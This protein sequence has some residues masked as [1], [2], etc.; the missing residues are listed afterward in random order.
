MTALGATPKLAKQ[1]AERNDD[2]QVWTAARCNRLLRQITSRVAHLRQ[3]VNEAV[4]VNRTTKRAV[5]SSEELPERKR[6]RHTYGG[7]RAKAMPLQERDGNTST[8]PRVMRAL[9]AMRPH[10][11]SSPAGLCCPTP[12]RPTLPTNGLSAVCHRG[13]NT[14][15]YQSRIRSRPHGSASRFLKQISG[16]IPPDRVKIY[17]AILTWLKRLLQLTDERRFEPGRNSLLGMC[18]RKM[19]ECIDEMDAWDRQEAETLGVSSLW[20]SDDAAATIYRQLEAFGGSEHG[21]MPFKHLVKSHVIQVLSRA[22]EEGLFTSEFVTTMA[23]TC[24]EMQCNAEAERLLVAFGQISVLPRERSPSCRSSVPAYS[25]ELC[26]RALIDVSAG[27]SYTSVMLP[28]LGGAISRQQLLIEDIPAKQRSSIWKGALAALHDISTANHGVRFLVPTL[29][30]L[31]SGHGKEPWSSQKSREGMLT[32]LSAGIAAAAITSEVSHDIRRHLHILEASIAEVVSNR[33]RS[34]KAQHSGLFLLTMARQ[35]VL[36]TDKTI[37][38]HLRLQGVIELSSL[39]SRSDVQCLYR[40]TVG[41]MCSIAH[42]CSRST[43]KASHEYLEML[44]M[45]LRD[46]PLP[47]WFVDGLRSEGAFVLAQKT[48]D[49]RDLAFAENLPET[50]HSYSA[51][52]TKATTSMF[53]GWRWEAGISEWVLPSPTGKATNGVSSVVPR[54]DDESFDIAMQRVKR[55]LR[56]GL[57]STE[58]SDAQHEHRLSNHRNDRND[59]SRSSQSGT[60]GARRNT[61]I[62]DGLPRDH[63][64]SSVPIYKGRP[65]RQATCQNPRV[66]SSRE[67]SNGEGLGTL[68]GDRRRDMGIDAKRGS[69]RRWDAGGR[70]YALIYSND[71]GFKDASQEVDYGGTKEAGHNKC[72][73]ITCQA[74]SDDCITVKPGDVAY[75]R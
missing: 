72:D 48:K 49:L 68:W 67:H 8:P 46:L 54:H 43:G 36:E 29:F 41:L 11:P 19:P 23:S 20:R 69:G 56:A 15:D 52:D 14:T 64:L 47:R 42:A 21:W 28:A 27:D 63:N 65:L 45:A 34:L 37:L 6:V 17:Q 13:S 51:Q 3:M 10:L 12:A 33:S 75:E 66:G 26:H 2:L 70:R 61:H 16:D 35:L 53:S 59:K 40:Q 60:L 18:L 57:V 9:G 58:C 5:D 32:S 39:I 73:C 4:N 1:D 22:T 62:I 31:A 25:R 30:A 24:V 38:A 55:H 7:R 50:R 44:R 74:S 71:E